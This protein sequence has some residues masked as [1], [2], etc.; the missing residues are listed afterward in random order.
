MAQNTNL[1]Y[2]LERFETV[3]PVP[4][5]TIEKRVGGKA[6]RT[7]HP[8]KIVI[9][10]V[11]F[12]AMACTV[13]YSRVVITELNRQVAAAEDELD[14]LHSEQVRMETE[15]ES[16]MSLKEIE[17]VAMGEYGMVKP[18]SGQVG[19]LSFTSENKIEGT[20]EQGNLLSDILNFFTGLF[21]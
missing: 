2:D 3:A 4:R 6:E 10:A 21:Q 14:I 12:V 8:I 18:D 19:Y 5:P 1:A 17:Q 13:L 20:G 16:K 9:L 11:L 7:T 15:L